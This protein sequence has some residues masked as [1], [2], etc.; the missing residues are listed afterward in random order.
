MTKSEKYIIT[1]INSKESNSVVTY[2]KG[3]FFIEEKGVQQNFALIKYDHLFIRIDHNCKGI[4][5]KIF[6]NFDQ[7]NY[8]VC[9]GNDLIS[10]MIIK[11]LPN[12]DLLKILNDSF[13]LYDLYIMKTF[14]KYNIDFK[15]IIYNFIELFSIKEEFKEIIES[16]QFWKNIISHRRINDMWGNVII[17]AD[18]LEK[19]ELNGIEW[20]SDYNVNERNNLLN[21][22]LTDD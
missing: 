22:L 8:K 2:K 14:K 3:A 15:K 17:D 16:D 10:K 21:D 19:E 13:F 6:K 9:L 1:A 12:E 4:C 5:K 11:D 7:I 18:D 20:V